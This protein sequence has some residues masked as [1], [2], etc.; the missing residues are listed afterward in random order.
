M[1]SPP[2]CA[3]AHQP[4]SLLP[5]EPFYSVLRHAAGHCLRPA[6]KT[7]RPFCARRSVLFFSDW[8]NTFLSLFL[9]HSFRAILKPSFPPQVVHETGNLLFPIRLAVGATHMEVR[10]GARTLPGQYPAERQIEVRS[11][12][13]GRFGRAFGTAPAQVYPSVSIY[14][15]PLCLFQKLIKTKPERRKKT[16][17]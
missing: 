12:G 13:Q 16:I 4:I 3:P 2:S 1:W 7:G 17:R 9:L 10:I 8:N 15:R 6:K 11:T 14:L 5:A